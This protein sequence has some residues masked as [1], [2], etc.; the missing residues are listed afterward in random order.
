MRSIPNT[1]KGDILNKIK[2]NQGSRPALLREGMSNLFFKGRVFVEE[3][4]D[5]NL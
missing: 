2:I 5:F 1:R 3:R 4:T